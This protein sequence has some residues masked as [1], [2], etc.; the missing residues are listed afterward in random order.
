LWG[1]KIPPGNYEKLAKILFCFDNLP[2]TKIISGSQDATGLVIP[3][4]AYAYYEGEYWPKRI[5][6]RLD[7]ALLRFVE[8]AL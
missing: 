7:E 3:A 6:H 4:L 8:N 2:G 1:V 5:E